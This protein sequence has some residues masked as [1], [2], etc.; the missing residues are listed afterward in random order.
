M[1]TPP[2]ERPW[3]GRSATRT[4]R[5]TAGLVDAFVALSGDSSAL[6]VSSDAA[7]A[8]GFEDRV[9]HGLLL[10]SLISGLVGT[11]LPGDRGVLQNVDLAFRNPCYVGDEV[12]AHVRVEDYIESV[13]TLILKVQVERQDGTVLVTGTLRSG[14][15]AL[16]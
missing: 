16:A 13:R 12:R 7:R 3:P 14:L 1:V 2:E 10:A 5:L 4:F 8:L 6:H 11:E 15:R 9:V